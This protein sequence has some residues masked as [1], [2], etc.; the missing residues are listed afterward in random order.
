M[1][2]D[3]SFAT[4]VVRLR[5]RDPMGFRQVILDLLFAA[6]CGVR[7]QAVAL[8]YGDVVSIRTSGPAAPND[9]KPLFLLAVDVEPPGT[10]GRS[11]GSWPGALSSLG[12]PQV[13]VAWLAAVRALLTTQGQRP[14]EI[15]YVR[16]PALGLDDYVQ[17]L[18]AQQSDDTDCVLLAPVVEGN[19]PL[20]TAPLDLARLDLVRSRNIWRFPACDFTWILTGEVPAGQALPRLRS[21]LAAQPGLNWTL[22]DLHVEPAAMSKVTGVLRTS[23]KLDALPDGMQLRPI[24]GEPRLMFPI[25]DA[26]TALQQVA[27]QGPPTWRDG[28]TAPLQVMSLPDGLAVHAVVPALDAEPNWPEKAGSLGVTWNVRSLTRRG[29]ADNVLLALEAHELRGPLPAG[30]ERARTA[31]R[32]PALHAD[33]DLTALTRALHAK[34]A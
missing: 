28:L 26:L 19:V 31:W 32:T 33:D 30:T 2:F 22:H 20:A 21:V 34:L 18:L 3:L 23:A 29:P 15:A 24:E 12:G 5:Y 16:G 17:A 11:G 4:R 14:W 7:E 8:E 13:A 27:Q 9:Q 1:P 10:V 25:N 6:S